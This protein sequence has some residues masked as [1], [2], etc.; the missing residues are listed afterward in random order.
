MKSLGRNNSLA[1]RA[2]LSLLLGL[3]AGVLVLGLM[4]VGSDGTEPRGIC[5]FVGGDAG[6]LPLDPN[7]GGTHSYS[8]DLNLSLAAFYILIPGMALSVL[9]YFSTGLF[10]SAWRPLAEYRSHRHDIRSTA[11]NEP[12]PE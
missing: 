7:E 11:T 2:S 8:C 9:F 5:E 1:L 3:I 10:L 6:L 12:R 4:L